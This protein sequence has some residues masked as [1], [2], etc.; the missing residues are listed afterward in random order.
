M[1][2]TQAVLHSHFLIQ[3]ICVNNWGRGHLAIVKS[4]VYS[5]SYLVGTG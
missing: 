4:K 5:S 1:S 2:S 3:F